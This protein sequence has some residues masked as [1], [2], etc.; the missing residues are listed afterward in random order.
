MWEH[1]DSIKEDGTFW[2]KKMNS[3]NHYAYG[4]VGEWMY[5]AIAGICIDETKP[6]YKHTIFRPIVT[7][8]LN[9]AHGSVESMYGTVALKWEHT[10][11]GVRYTVDIPVN[12]T[13]EV[14]VK[15][16]GGYEILTGE[17]AD[18]QNKDGNLSLHLGSGHY[19][20]IVY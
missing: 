17:T 9:F 18:I 20:M 5:K 10:D 6:A 13:A 3:F 1:W 14:H 11:R 19:E 2:D 15:M 8:R 7:D 16:T 12:T 4:S